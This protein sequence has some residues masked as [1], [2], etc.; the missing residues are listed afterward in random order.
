L[1]KQRQA[2]CYEF[3]TSLHSLLVDL[4]S[5]T[6]NRKKRREKKRK[7]TKEKEREIE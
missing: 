6:K 5:T 3:E 2:D 4:M 1:R 7:K